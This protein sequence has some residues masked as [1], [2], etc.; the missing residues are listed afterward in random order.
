MASLPPVLPMNHPTIRFSASLVAALAL[1]ASARAVAGAVLVYGGPAY[2]RAT[3]TGYDSPDLPVAPGA[4]VGN[5]MAVGAGFKYVGGQGFGTRAVRWDTSGNAAVELGNLGTD[6]RG[7]TNS[8]AYAINAAGTTVGY[9]TKYSGGTFLDRRAVRWDASGTAATE[10]GNLG[11]D[12][13]GVSNS[14]AFAVNAG[15]TA[16]GVAYKYVGTPPVLIGT[17]AV[18]WN[19]SGTAATE[20]GI[21]ATD[22]FGSSTAAAWAINNA[23]TAVGFAH[24]NH[25][26][27]VRWDAGGTAVT[28]LGSLDAG[29]GNAQGEALAI[30]TAGTAVGYSYKYTGRPFE[31]DLGT[32]A[33]RWNAGGTAATELD[34][35]GTDSTGQT[36]SRAY[37]VNDAGTAVGYAVKYT[38]AGTDLFTRA[39][40]WDA[41]GTAATELGKLGTDAD[42]ITNT[43]ANAINAAGFTVGEAH[44]YAN[45]AFVSRRAVLWG[46]D[47]VAIDLNTLIDPAGGWTL[48]EARGISDGNWVSGVGLFDPDG[49]GPL[50]FY[51]RAFLLDVSSVVPEP[52]SSLTILLG[53]I[54][55]HGWRRR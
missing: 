47:A 41:G 50:P 4:T 54:L 29:T 55:L 32:R 53:A 11:T 48:S 8:G 34:N 14:T 24:N 18:R 37:A 31:S 20:L 16:A 15:G 1:L 30:N 36:F 39:V 23:G 38:A 9:A 46:P 13:S 35:L 22:S 7:A 26:R 21:L 52:A 19:A 6:G 2:D 51:S 49:A 42:G 10:L 33:V 43:V 44:K 3:Q 12:S 27:P 45:G 28:E 17:R 40:R 25:D 5:G